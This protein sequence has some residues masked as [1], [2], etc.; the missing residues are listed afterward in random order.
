M[1]SDGWRDSLAP[2]RLALGR[3]PKSPAW[4]ELAAAISA[5]PQPNGLSLRTILLALMP[6]ANDQQ[7][8]WPGN[9]V[10][11]NIA[12][13]SERNHELPAQRPA[14]WRPAIQHWRALQRLRGTQYCVTGLHR[15]QQIL[16][17]LS[18]VKQMV[19]AR[20]FMPL[21]WAACRRT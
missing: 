11:E 13:R 4:F 6:D 9:L 19:S 21:N 17:V 7:E 20:R 1:A 14:T 10:L 15:N 3:G 16:R 12:L 2:L 8:I 5:M 18:T